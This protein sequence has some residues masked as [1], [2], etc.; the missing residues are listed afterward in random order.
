MEELNACIDYLMLEGQSQR[1]AIHNSGRVRSLEH[2]GIYL[3]QQHPLR[4]LLKYK[5]LAPKV[6]ESMRDHAINFF[7]I[8][9]L[10]NPRHMH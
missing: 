1:M 3:L 4:H 9:T 7:L 8:W 10:F 2:S 5:D 6:F